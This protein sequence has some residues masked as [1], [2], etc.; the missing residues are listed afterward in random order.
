MYKG[1]GVHHVGTGVKNLAKMREFYGKTLAFTQVWEVFEETWNPM[2]D[3]FRASTHKLD[4]IMFGQEAG[5][6]IVEL[7]H[8]AIPLPRPIRKDIRY[9]D[10]GVN[11]TTIAVS[12]VGKFH[13]EYKDKMTFCSEPKSTTIPGLGT[14]EFVFGRDPEGN[15]IEFFS[16]AG[17]EVQGT[18]GGCRWLGVSVTD[19]ERSKAFY[20]NHAGFDTVVVEPHEKLSGLVDEVAGARNA[21]VRSCLLSNSG[22]GG[23]LELYELVKPRGRSIPFNARWGDFGYLEVALTCEDIFDTAKELGAAG[24]DFHSNPTHIDSP[25]ADAWFLYA[26][27]PDGIPVEIISITPK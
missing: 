24:V 10:I 16:D 11:K 1:Q 4:G 13:K 26:K 18:F 20:Q 12:N 9:G 27:D 6:V 5:G 15:L 25:D 7:I 21:Q 22:G 2:N 14:Y 23:M 17:N 8:M 3:M 19:L